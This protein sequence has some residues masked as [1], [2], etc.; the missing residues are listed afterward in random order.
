MSP[1]P[2]EESWVR[3]ECWLAANAPGNFARLNPPAVPSAIAAAEE[4]LGRV[5]PED[6]RRVL[7]L[8]NGTN[9]HD[10]S[11][12][13]HHGAGLLPEFGELLPVERIA[14]VH[15]MRVEIMQGHMEV[16]EGFGEWALSNWWHPDWLPIA[17][18]SSADG[19]FLDQRDG[20]D[21]GTHFILGRPERHGDSAGRRWP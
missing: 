21:Q 9:T 7:L 18:S 20:A 8:R 14:G 17:D 13:Y 11:G 12:N 19:L 3:L 1:A 15:A 2:V 10:L 16:E 6:L 4:A 5:F